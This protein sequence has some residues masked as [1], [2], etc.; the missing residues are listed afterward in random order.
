MHRIWFYF[1]HDKKKGEEERE[2]VQD[3]WI[4]KRGRKMY[5]DVMSLTFFICV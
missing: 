1:I 3:K 4:R 2:K 5:F